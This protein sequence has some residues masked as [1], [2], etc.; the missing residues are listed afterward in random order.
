MGQ[1]SLSGALVGGPASGGTT[2][3]GST[4]SIPLALRTNP[5]GFNAATGVLQRQIQT[6][7]G[8]FVALNEIGPNGSVQKADTIYLN[9]N[10]PLTVR[11]T[12]DDGLGGSV[13][14]VLP[15]SGYTMIELDSTRFCK[16]LEVSGSALIE[17]FASGQS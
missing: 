7:L 15:V 5:K 6:A 14:A 17:Y 4:I 10:G 9:S 13:V 16:L 2:F 1:L 3:P 11:Y 8:V 12:T